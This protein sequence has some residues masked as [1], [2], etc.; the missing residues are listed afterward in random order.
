MTNLPALPIL[1]P[2]PARPSHLASLA[3]AAVLFGAPAAV[4]QVTPS[5]GAAPSE[6]ALPAITVSEVAPHTLRDRVIASGLV[7]AVEEVQVQPLVDGQPIDALL[8][9]VGDRVEA[10]Q[11]LARL[12]GST[13]ELQ[14]S[15][16]EAS[17]ASA[18]AATAQAEAGLAEAVSGADEADRVAARSAQLAE[19]GTIPRSQAE[20]ATAAAAAARARARAAEQGIAVAYAQGELLEAQVATLDLQLARTEV[21][22]S[23]AGLVVAR[24]AQVGAVASATGTPMFTLVRDGAM[25][26]RAD[27]SEGDLLRLGVGQ[28]VTLTS[29]GSAEPLTGTLRLVEPSIDQ[30]TRLG[31]A[32]IAIDDP[33]RVVVGMFLTAEILAAEGDVLAVPV[34][35]VS[36]GADGAFVMR[37]REGVVARIPVTTSIRDGG[38]IGVARGLAAGDLVVTKAAAFVR[39]G[40]SITPVRDQANMVLAQTQGN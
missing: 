12:S 31:R 29:I 1:F 5:E 3:L 33:S 7:A 30:D 38:L 19:Q 4:A 27:V 15:E 14:M 8:A 35:A 9:D 26:M 34:T 23:V 17:R 40:D 6:V 13:L 21:R 11:V 36:A 37:V 32:R 24:N 22:A 39:E 25:E 10:G 20:E 2:N 18:R 28:S 16:L